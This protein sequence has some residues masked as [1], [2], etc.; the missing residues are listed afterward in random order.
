MLYSNIPVNEAVCA[1]DRKDRQGREDETSAEEALIHGIKAIPSRHRCLDF[2]FRVS[3]SLIVIR[4]IDGQK[5]VGRR[6][7]EMLASGGKRLRSNWASSAAVVAS[8]YQERLCG[9]RGGGV[10]V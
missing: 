2:K 6:S 7:V 4:S 9:R 1:R 3:Q 8:Y 10:Q 5:C